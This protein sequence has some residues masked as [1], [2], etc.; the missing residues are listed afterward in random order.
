MDI[1][2]RTVLFLSFAFA[3]KK[4]KKKNSDPLPRGISFGFVPQT[5]HDTV[6][7]KVPY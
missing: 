1:Y 7:N 2:L 3:K 5:I 6:F 4:K